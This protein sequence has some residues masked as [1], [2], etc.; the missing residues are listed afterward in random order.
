MGM[1]MRGTVTLGARL[2]L[3]VFKPTIQIICLPYV[4]RNPLVLWAELR[5]DVVPCGIFE[6]RI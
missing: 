4:N 3:M 2:F 6:I 1:D 5:K